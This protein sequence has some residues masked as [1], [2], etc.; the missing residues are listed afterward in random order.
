MELLD[1]SSIRVHHR[2]LTWSNA[3]SFSRILAAGILVPVHQHF[4][5]ALLFT[6]LVIWI[7]ASDYLDGWMARRTDNVSE[8]GKYLDPTA[9]KIAA[10]ILFV[11]AGFAE[12]IPWWFIS[13]SVA[14]DFLIGLGGTL[15]RWKRGKTM[16]AVWS[17]KVA[18]NAIALYWLVAMYMP[19]S[20]ALHIFLQGA[21]VM[22]L[23][24]AFHEY[25]VRSLKAW[26]GADFN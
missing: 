16:M 4:G 12:T 22:M 8:L 1:T 20:Q 3:F 14:R 24:Y 2:I 9:D 5:A 18:V 7:A 19:D 23:L 6:A 17:G 25:V 13:F 15:V 11:Y 26:H 10:A 21:C